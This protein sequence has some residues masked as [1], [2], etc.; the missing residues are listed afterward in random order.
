[1]ELRAPPS[2]TETHRVSKGGLWALALTVVVL[3]VGVI[4]FMSGHTGNQS[5]RPEAR[6]IASKLQAAG[7]LNEAAALYEQYLDSGPE[8]ADPNRAQIAYS[9]GSLYLEAGRY[10]KAL[11]WL[12]DAQ[13]HDSGAMQT[14]ISPKIVHALE[15]MG[16]PF[17]A[18]AALAAQTRLDPVNPN[19]Q[20]PVDDPVVAKAGDQTIYKSE[21]IRFID[22]LPP[23]LQKQ[24]STPQQKEQLLRQYVADTL[25]LNK[26]HKLELDKDPKVRAQIESM[27]RQLIVGTFLEREVFAK[28]QISDADLQNYFVANKAK[29]KAE[30]L[31]PVRPQVEQDYRM[32]KGQSAYSDL[33]KQELTHEDVALFPDKMAEAH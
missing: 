31:D 27:R 12:Y 6:T 10:E 30:T 1:M 8:Q 9:L 7:A 5:A 25:F 22:N 2:I 29:Y 26:A 32:M 15:S 21:V 17:A 28:I 14:E 13:M 19:V 4:L 18:R 23:Q 24:L 16:K 33:V 3:N 20:R 11:R